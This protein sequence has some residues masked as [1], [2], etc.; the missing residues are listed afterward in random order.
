VV[1]KKKHL[2]FKLADMATDLTA[3]RLMIRT[4]A[5]KLEE[6]TPDATVYCSMAKKFSTDVGFDVCAF[7]DC[8]EVI[9]LLLCTYFNYFNSPIY[10]CL[11]L[12]T[13][14]A[15][16]IIIIIIIYY[17]LIINRTVCIYFK[18]FINNFALGL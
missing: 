10:S 2:Q 14:Y 13:Y 16:I 7:S 12:Y 3:A 5:A 8:F 1:K 15:L 9:L 18:F 17:A 6:Q 4:A 11:L